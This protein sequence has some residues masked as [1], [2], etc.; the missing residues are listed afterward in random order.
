[1]AGHSGQDAASASLT[2]GQNTS[3][4]V[5]DTTTATFGQDVITASA[6]QPVLVD[7]WA[8]W[9]EPCKQLTPVLEKVAKAAAGK[10][11][12][13]KMN[14][15]ENPQIPARLG[16]RSIPAVIAFNRAQPVDGFMG[17][18]PESQV[19]GFVER[20][21]GPLNEE[22][23]LLAEAEALLA[24]ED[25]VGA[26]ELFSVLVKEDPGNFP[27]VAGL[28]KS[29]LAAGQIDS[30][31]KILASLPASGERDVAI[32][33]AKAAI[34]LAEQT[35]ALGDTADLVRKIEADPTDHQARFDYALLLNS[36]GERDAA[37][38]ALLDIFKR[39][40]QWNEEG[41]RKQLLQFFEAWGPTDPATIAA[42]KKLSALLFS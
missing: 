29:F 20:L 2:G 1:M 31:K 35:A 4:T 5:T 23:N 13:V 37:A 18:L 6:Q 36:N 10:I 3:S 34:E 17:A 39:D 26:A 9:C 12:I 38:A 22:E 11:K 41:A 24:A 25:P 21:V 14:I 8:P 28:A 30:A 40:R 42:R 16:V 7:F 19:R 32:L 33:A 15:D 27:A